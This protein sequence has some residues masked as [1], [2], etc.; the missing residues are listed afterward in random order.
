MGGATGFTAATTPD[1]SAGQ[2]S[3]SPLVSSQLGYLQQMSPEQ[4]QEL[5][6]RMGNTP[7]GQMAQRLLA[8]KRILNAGQANNGF[9]GTQGL[10]QTPTQP[11]QQQTPYARGGPLHGPPKAYAMGGDLEANGGVYLPERGLSNSGFLNTAGPGRSDNI[12]I[13]AASNSYV[14]PADVVAG[15]GEGNSLA[16]AKAIEAALGT[17]PHGIPMQPARGGHRGIPAP[18]PAYRDPDPNYPFRAAGGQTQQHTPVVVAGGEY[19]ISPQQVAAIG[20]G[21]T[22]HGF[23]ILDAF[24]KHVRQ[25][26]IKQMRKLKGPVKS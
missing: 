5:A 15:L 10:G 4:L 18:P 14:L 16:G 21:D 7:Q 9:G 19:I 26:T 6:L 20:G 2:Y 8:Q 23:K 1:N 12:N 22:K 25:R 24:V 11:A 13:N 17:G 3:V